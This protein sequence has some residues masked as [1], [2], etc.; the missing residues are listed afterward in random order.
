MA[1]RRHEPPQ[2]LKERD[3]AYQHGLE[4]QAHMRGV[5]VEEAAREAQG[6]VM[7]GIPKARDK[8]VD[9]DGEAVV[10]AGC[11]S[12]EFGDFHPAMLLLFPLAV[13]WWLVRKLRRLDA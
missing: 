10:E 7:L 2:S 8:S 11:M 1:W 12:F 6:S 13:V 3:A 9:D 5:S 4:L